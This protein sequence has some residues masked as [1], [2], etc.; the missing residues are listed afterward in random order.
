VLAPLLVALSLLVVS[1]HDAGRF[2]PV[3]LIP[4][5]A[6][7][8]QSALDYAR[9]YVQGDTVY[10]YGGQD[11]LRA[12]RID[13][14]GLV[15][16]CYHYALEGT[17]CSLPFEDAAVIDF[18]RDWTQETGTPRPGDLVFMGEGAVPDHMSMFVKSEGG[19]IYF[20][21]STFKPEDG[22]DGVSERY[23]PVG[24]TRFIAFG[25]LLLIPPS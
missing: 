20:I 7:T 15:V 9:E 16:N 2:S 17:G 11:G 8:A 23:Y 3:N 4:C 21:D 6:S 1:C 14:S 19:Y 25:V 22:I 24:D 10:E 18:Y 13:C 12:I 5:P